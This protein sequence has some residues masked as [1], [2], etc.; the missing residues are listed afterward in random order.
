MKIV[1]KSILGDYRG[2]S[3]VVFGNFSIQDNSV[4]SPI[5]VIELGDWAKQG[6]SFYSGA[7]TYSQTVDLPDQLKKQPLVLDFSA[8]GNSAAISVNGISIVQRIAPPW[9]VDISQFNE[10]DVLSIEITVANTAANIWGGD[11][12]PSGLLGPVTIHTRACTG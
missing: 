5:S 6:L 4:S 12:T 2:M 9:T 10:C 1:R 3:P 11:N 8:P 7:A